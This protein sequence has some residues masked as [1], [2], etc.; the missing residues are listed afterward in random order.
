MRYTSNR[1]AVKKQGAQ[2]SLKSLD[3]QLDYKLK[4]FGILRDGRACVLARPFQHCIKVLWLRKESSRLSSSL[5][6]SFGFESLFQDS[7]PSLT[8]SV[9]SPPLLVLNFFARLGQ[10]IMKGSRVLFQLALISV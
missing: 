5:T 4:R 3:K 7:R 8:C 2:S 9:S 1:K 6:V 10:C